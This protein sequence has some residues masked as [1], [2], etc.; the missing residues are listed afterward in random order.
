MPKIIT[1][2]RGSRGSRPL[3]ATC[4]DCDCSF[5]FERHETRLKS[6][7]TDDD[8]YPGEAKIKVVNCPECGKEVN[9]FPHTFW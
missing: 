8:G 4:G 5:T 9:P 6:I 2:G 3:D 7:E 1:P